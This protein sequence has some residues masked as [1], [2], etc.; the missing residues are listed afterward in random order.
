MDQSVTIF[1]FEPLELIGAKLCDDPSFMKDFVCFPEIKRTACG[2]RIY[3]EVTSAEWFETA[4]NNSP[5]TANGKLIP[6]SLFVV[7]LTTNRALTNL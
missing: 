7:F 3:N 4:F 2:Q 5:A 6:G 1:Y